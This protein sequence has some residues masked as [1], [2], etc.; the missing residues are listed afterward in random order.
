MPISA[1]SRQHILTALCLVVNI[2][3]CPYV[4]QGHVICQRDEFILKFLEGFTKLFKV[5][6]K[7]NVAVFLSGTPLT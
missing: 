5:A 2:D 3:S 7:C 6:K 1:K 4:G